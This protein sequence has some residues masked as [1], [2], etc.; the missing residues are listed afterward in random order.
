MLQLLFMAI[1]VATTISFKEGLALCLTPAIAF[2]LT[3]IGSSKCFIIIHLT[4]THVHIRTRFPVLFYTPLYST[5][6]PAAHEY[7]SAVVKS[8]RCQPVFFY[9]ARTLNS[10]TLG[11]RLSLIMEM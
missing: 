4:V 10:C 8:L 11:K 1:L 7:G 3:F 5:P 9:T 2:K 6:H